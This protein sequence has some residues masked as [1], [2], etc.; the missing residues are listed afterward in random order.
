[1]NISFGITV[2]NEGK[3]LRNL[4]DFIFNNIGDYSH[5]IVIVDDFSDDEDTRNILEDVGLSPI[6]S[7]YQHHFNN[8]YSAQKNFLNSKCNG[9]YIFQIDA[10]ELPSEYILQNIH[11]IL[12]SYDVDL[13]WVPRINTVK[14]LTQEHIQ[15]WKWRVNEKGWVNWPD[16]QCRIYKN[17]PSVKWKNKVHEVI[18]GYKSSAHLPEIEKCALSH[19]K[20]IDKQEQQIDKYFKMVKADSRSEG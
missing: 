4:L 11:K 13:C 20:T 16:Y 14:G 10:D 2:H 15:Q 19:H 7:I 18:E 8:N 17:I 6:V 12:S 5:E 1:M 3:Y 9:A